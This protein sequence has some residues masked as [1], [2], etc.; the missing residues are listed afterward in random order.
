MGLNESDKRIINS[1]IDNPRKS[2]RQLAKEAK[3]S[4]ATIGNRLKFLQKEKI[5]LG[6]TT[7]LNYS[8]IG[9]DFHVLINIKVSHGHT[10]KIERLLSNEANILSIFDIT[11]KYDVLII[12]RFQDRKSLDFFLKKLQSYD[13]IERTET[14][15]ILKTIKNHPINIR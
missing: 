2:Y 13:F 6:Y 12:A 8:K 14:Q 7:L 4:I 10:E 3:V 15:L 11:G 5:I 1:L 9:Y